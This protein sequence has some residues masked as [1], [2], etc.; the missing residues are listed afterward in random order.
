MSSKTKRRPIEV[1]LEELDQILD[2]TSIGPL[3]EAERQ[4]L[5]VAIHAMVAR[6]TPK[7]NTEK[8]KAVLERLVPET[9]PLAE[10]SIAN[11]EETMQPGGHGRNGAAAFVG[12]SRVTIP[13]A[14]LQPGQ[15]CPECGEGKVYRQRDPATLVR[16]VGQAPLETTVFDISASALV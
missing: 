7:R 12:A 9:R 1:N 3:S 8:T 2:R 15:A 6:L 14:T 16:I 4:K 13:H 10:K 5:R 11:E